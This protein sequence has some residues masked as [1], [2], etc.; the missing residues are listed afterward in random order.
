MRG[1]ACCAACLLFATLPA[2]AQQLTLSVERI[3]HAAF[4][5]R[6]L[7]LQMSDRDAAVDIGELKVAGRSWRGAKLR[8]ERF[9]WRGG[10]FEC[11]GGKIRLADS[12]PIGIS[13]KYDTDSGTL[14]LDVTQAPLALLRPWLP[15]AAGWS[16]DG[17]ADATL[18]L[19]PKLLSVQLRVADASFADAAG[20]HAGEH[21]G[22]TL[23]AS[24]QKTGADAWDWQ[25]QLRWSGGDVFWQP[26]FLKS[27][28]QSLA[29]QGHYDGD[30]LSV[31]DG[32]AL[33]GGLGRVDFSLLWNLAGDSLI[34]ARVAATQ[35][36][37]AKAGPTL[38]HP[39]LE[40]ARLPK[41]E[42]GGVMGVALEYGDGLVQ[43]LDIDL[44]DVSVV[45]RDPQG[46]SRLALGGLN[47]HVPWRRHDASDAVIDA[48]G[49]SLG[50]L[51]FGAVH[52]PLYMNG[53]E[54]DLVK[55]EIPV[56]DGKL[57]LENFHALRDA[58]VWQWQV[59][60]A[61]Q[62]VSME[63]LTDSLGLPH[64]RGLLSATVPKITY[65][66]GTLLL[67]GDLVISVFDG[68]VSA[69]GLKVVDPLGTAPRVEANLEMRHFDL[70]MLTE[71]FSFGDI[72]GYLDADVRDLELVEWRPQHFAARLRS[73]P[74]DYRR[75]ISQRAVQD[76]SALGGAGAAAAI[77]RSFLGVFKTFGY[78]KIGLTATLANG[79][80]AMDGVEPAPQ[81]YVIVKGGGI[82]A[83]SVIGYNRHVQWDELMNRLIGVIRSHGTPVIR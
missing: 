10:L 17:R 31:S 5:A 7:R 27:E 33:L 42:L 50:K 47:A 1:I 64:M 22:A 4:S 30:G 8:C 37:L 6:D 62:P 74:G 63:Q 76:I 51:P 73:S 43:R 32:R 11:R 19:T 57:V 24:A 29:L 34:S 35:V 61:M 55:T 39:F 70:G 38:L 28:G 48:A 46:N 56:L 54:F 60:G 40:Q 15:G 36:D 58:G 72:T 65:H 2:A 13:F 18:H 25:A 83:L 82:P 69:T 71:T 49:G 78:D 23:A 20:N 68:Y 26:L 3:D 67:D 66:D 59:A 21:L 77:E 16:V 45:D 53:F 12:A 14:D 41:P 81:G 80:C 79:V 52:L 44:V 75:R 9:V